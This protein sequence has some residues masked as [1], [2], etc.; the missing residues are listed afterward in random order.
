[1]VL[2]TSNRGE[3]QR[4]S[5]GYVKEYYDEYIGGLPEEYTKNRW[6]SSTVS[7]LDHRQTRRSLLRALGNGKYNNVVEVGPGDGA[8]TTDILKHV[9]GSMYLID[10]SEEM[11]ARAKARLSEYTNIFYEVLDFLNANTPNNNDLLVSVRC[12]EYFTDKDKA[13][14]KMYDLLAPNGRLILITKNSEFIS[15][16]PKQMYHFTAHK[17]EEVTYF[18]Y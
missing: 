8:W 11:I 7:K 4:L 5:H 13:A 1:M 16:T 14:Q 10:Q 3:K 17:A 12:F 9:T 15:T 18:V 6:F 2:Q